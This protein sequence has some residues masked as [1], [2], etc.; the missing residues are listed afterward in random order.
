MKKRSAWII[1]T[2]LLIIIA[3]CSGDNEKEQLKNDVTRLTL[4]LNNCQNDN[5]QI[6]NQ[7][8]QVLSELEEK[9]FTNTKLTKDIAEADIRT[10]GI[11]LT[12]I[13]VSLVALLV[14][15]L[16]WLIAYRRKK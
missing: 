8:S 2:A 7:K 14:N 12:I 1:L 5:Q 16:L 15:N 3:A 9:N 13:I 10:T 11:S 4:K 6:K